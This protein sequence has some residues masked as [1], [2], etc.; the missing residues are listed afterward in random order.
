MFRPAPISRCSRWVSIVIVALA[1]A[2]PAT[3]QQVF[4]LGDDD[5][6]TP[7][8]TIDPETPE[9]A[10]E[11]ARRTLASG[12]TERAV[13]LA[14]EWIERHPDH[15]RVAHAYLLRGDALRDQEEFYRA[16]FDYEH[17]ARRHADTDAFVP[18]LEREFEIAARFAGG[19][20]RKLWACASSTRT[21]RRRRSS[22]SFRS[23]SRAVGWRNERA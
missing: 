3:A 14:T 22:S 13:F 18:A 6:W 1:V 2:W 4:R 10:L 23:D 15:P 12:E 7:E 5:T 16:L 8:S 19:L 21:K 9:G 20:K 11:V 17:V